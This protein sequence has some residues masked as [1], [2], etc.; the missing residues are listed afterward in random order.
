VS[1]AFARNPT[2]G[3]SVATID[4]LASLEPGLGGSEVLVRNPIVTRAIHVGLVASA[5]L[6][7]SSCGSHGG[8]SNNASGAGGSSD[9][10]ADSFENEA[11]NGDY[12][13]NDMDSN[14]AQSDAANGTT[15]SGGVN[16]N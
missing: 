5:A 3:V 12:G 9:A 14:V 16:N 6:I 2:S 15:V 4:T 7:A 11:K 13:E 10:G 1:A 8:S